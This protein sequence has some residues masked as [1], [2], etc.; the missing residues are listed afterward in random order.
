[1][2]GLIVSLSCGIYSIECDGVI[3]NAPARGVFRTKG[4]KPTVGDYVE[5]T[6]FGYNDIAFFDDNN[7]ILLRTNTHEGFVIVNEYIDKL[8]RK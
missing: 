3:Y 7:N 4:V 6:D 2:R 1:M 5:I 8:Y